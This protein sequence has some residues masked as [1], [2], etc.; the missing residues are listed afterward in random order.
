MCYLNPVEQLIEVEI[1]GSDRV[2]KIWEVLSKEQVEA[3]IE[4]LWKFKDIFA[5]IP[6]DILGTA[7]LIITR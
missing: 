7:T 3:L 2:V 6:S 1:G 4:L 5:W